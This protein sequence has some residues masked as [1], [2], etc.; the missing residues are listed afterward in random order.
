[1]LAGTRWLWRGLGR[2]SWVASVASVAWL[3]LMSMATLPAWV[4]NP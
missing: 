3:M 1:M 2:G 4:T